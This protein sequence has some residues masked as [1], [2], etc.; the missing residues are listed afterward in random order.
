MPG[1]GEMPQIC[2]SG[3][4]VGFSPRWENAWQLVILFWGITIFLAGGKS[5]REWGT[6]GILGDG[7]EREHRTACVFKDHA[8][9]KNY[10][11]RARTKKTTILIYVDF[12]VKRA[13]ATNAAGATAKRMRGDTGKKEIAFDSA[14]MTRCSSRDVGVLDLP[15]KKTRCKRGGVCFFTPRRD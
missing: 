5:G 1:A 13:A 3:S 6:T 8:P 11:R 14:S 15:T 2:E 4:S 12:F 7:G 10:T 9:K